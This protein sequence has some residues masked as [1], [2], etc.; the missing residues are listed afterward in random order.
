MYMCTD[1]QVWIYSTVPVYTVLVCYAVCACSLQYIRTFAGAVQ[2]SAVQYLHNM[3][4]I[5][6]IYLYVLYVPVFY[7]YGTVYRYTCTSTVELQYSNTGTVRYVS[8]GTR[9]VKKYRYSH[10]TCTGKIH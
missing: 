1:R 7:L 4:S 2:C 9:T 5:C 8:T 3:S 10:S 6:I